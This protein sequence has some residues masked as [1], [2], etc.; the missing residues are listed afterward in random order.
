MAPRMREVLHALV[1]NALRTIDVTLVMLSFGFGAVIEIKTFQWTTIAGFLESKV[2]LS[3]CV[4]FAIA[5][6]LC[7]GVFSLC[8]LYESKRMSTK[9]AEVQDVLRAMTFST[10]CICLEGRLFSISLV[11][12]Q[13]LLVFWAIGSALMVSTRFVLR[14]TLGAIRR[15]GHNLHH[16]LVLGTNPRAVE[17]GRRIQIMPDRGYRLLGF[18]DDDWPGMEAFRHTGFPVVCGYPDLPEFLRNN[19]V[20]EI[21]IYLPLRSL[22]EQAVVIAQ[23]ARQHGILLRC[24][25][26]I[27]DL[28][29]FS[30]LQSELSGIPPQIV[31]HGSR[32]DGWPL[33]FKRLFDLVGSSLSLILLSPLF[34]LVAALIKLTSPG[35]VLFVQ[36][37]VGLNKREFSM[38]KFRTM[39]PN[40]E[41]VQ[42]KLA[43]LNEMSGPVFKI[44]NDPRITPVGRILRK[45]SIDELPQLINVLTGDMSLVGPRAM[46]VRDYRLFSSDDWQRRRFSVR[47]G[48]TCLW[49]VQGRNELPFE[50][51]MQLDMQYIDG[52][53]L[54]LDVKILARTIPA[55]LRGVGAG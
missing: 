24:D 21:V 11:T 26:D 52:W 34:L 55:V 46:S 30:D 36:K 53:S 7:Y 29:R 25:T 45:T 54:W 14:F 38:F 31:P 9:T 20:D 49:Q 16:V 6:L 23:L 32:I 27:F 22:Y 48:I 40:A 13:F 41:S 12:P 10:L 43:H 51:W 50:Q 15:R 44:K 35:P 1:F 18:V 8:G 37:R 2:S 4:L 33:F 17:F 3:S 28:G 42:E 47:P 39:I 5:I 19:V